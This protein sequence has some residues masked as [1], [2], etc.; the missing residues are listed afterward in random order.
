M[1]TL[2]HI[3]D[4]S[5]LIIR[6][7]KVDKSLRPPKVEKKVAPTKIWNHMHNHQMGLLE[8]HRKLKK[9]NNRKK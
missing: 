1:A 4:S 5:T 7:P 8:S 9:N 6:T 3:Q 2:Q